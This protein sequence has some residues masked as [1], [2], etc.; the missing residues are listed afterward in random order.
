[1]IA[2]IAIGTATEI[3]SARNAIDATTTIVGIQ[4]VMTIGGIQDEMTIGG[5]NAETTSDER[6]KTVTRTRNA[7]AMMMC[8]LLHEAP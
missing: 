1:M 2:E 7:N 4:D 3:E 6:M 5:R 8:G